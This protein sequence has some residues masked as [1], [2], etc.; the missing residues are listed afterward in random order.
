MPAYFDIH[1]IRQQAESVLV[2]Y[3]LSQADASTL[4]DSMLRA[5]MYGVNTHGIRMLPAYIEKLKKGAFFLGECRICKQTPAF[6]LLDARNTV[7]AVCAVKAV[8]IAITQA[9]Q[10]GVHAVFS[11]HANTLGPGFYYVEKIAQAHMLG[12]VCSNAPAAMPAFNGLEA[13]LGTNPLAFA[14][15]SK[16]YGNLLVDMASSVVAKS[17]FATAKE[18]GEKLQPGWALDKEGNPTTDPQAA[19]QGFVLPMAGFKGYG[20]ALLIDILAGLLSGAGYLNKVGKFY[21]PTHA[22]MNVGHVIVALNPAL[23]YEGDYLAAMD[24]YIQ[25][26]KNSKSVPGKHIILPGEDRNEH[27]IQAV[28]KGLSL[29]EQTVAKLEE[30][31]QTPLRKQDPSHE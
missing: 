21:S 17:K 29:P 6:T 1:F 31:F 26:L 22:C 10:Y 7:G 28:Q 12:L 18:K 14:T 20:L 23:L 15:P 24:Q 30:I 9:Q 2:K 4:T 11:H 8:Q 13:L 3:G 19:L 5:D 25:T 27:Y 16:S